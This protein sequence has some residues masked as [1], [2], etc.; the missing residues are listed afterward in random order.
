[1]KNYE[2]MFILH[3][4]DHRGEDETEPDTPEVVIQKLIEKVGGTVGPSMVWAN[5]KL[6]YPIKGNQTG[7]YIICYFSGESGT[8]DEL[9]RE[10]KLSD[11]VLRAMAIAIEALPKEDEMPEPLAEPAS[12]SGRRF[13]GDTSAELGKDGEETRK[14]WELLD[15]KNPFVLRRMVSAQ[16]KLF[17]RVRSNLEAKSQRRL[18]TAVF[19]ARNMALL[20]FVGR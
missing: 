3:N 9:N 13:E 18:R 14:I 2:G 20:P 16:G 7:T 15:Y 17:S 6:A 11:R 4:R 8:I 10:V 19:R 12:R 5:R 1:M